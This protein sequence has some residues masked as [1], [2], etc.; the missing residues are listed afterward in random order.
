MK[1]FRSITTTKLCL[2]STNIATNQLFLVG[3]AM[4]NFEFTALVQLG[5]GQF[6][7]DFP[8]ELWIRKHQE[9]NRLYI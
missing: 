9:T 8:N 7:I 1:I 6:L 2:W 5:I 4:L 3:H